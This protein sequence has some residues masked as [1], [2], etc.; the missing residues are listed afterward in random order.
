MLTVGREE[1]EVVTGYAKS[2]REPGRPQP[3]Q[4]S[5]DIRES[6]LTLRFG[7]VDQA[8]SGFGRVDGSGPHPIEPDSVENVSG[9]PEVVAT[10]LKIFQ[11]GH[12]RD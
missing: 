3:D 6:E 9:L 8:S 1:M 10:R 11:T 7:G 12:R 5:L 2:A 4:S